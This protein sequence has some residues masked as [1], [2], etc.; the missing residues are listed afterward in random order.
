MDLVVKSIRSITAS[1][2]AHP[3]SADELLRAR[4]PILEADQREQ[5]QNGDWLGPVSKAQSDP[6]EL[7]RHRT[8]AAAIGAITAA[9][10]QAEA[11]RWLTAEPLQIRALPEAAGK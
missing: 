4:K 7:V 8:A 6:D 3:A 10:I 5:R 11:K 1:L 2:V 9:D